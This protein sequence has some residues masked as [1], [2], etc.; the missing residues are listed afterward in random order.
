MRDIQD[1]VAVILGFQSVG[2]LVA[3]P[4][5]FK[6]P[7][8]KMRLEMLIWLTSYIIWE[9]HRDLPLQ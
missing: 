6:D 3:E 8:Q 5:I 7:F 9:M 2:I 4:L 1:I